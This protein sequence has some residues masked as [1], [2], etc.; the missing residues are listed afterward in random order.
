MWESNVNLFTGDPKK[1]IEETIEISDLSTS[2]LDDLIGTEAADNLR[3][4]LELAQGV[5]PD[6]SKEEYV[7]GNLQPV[8]FGSALNNFGVPYTIG[9]FMGSCL[10]P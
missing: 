6:C 3:D 2:E 9:E 5:Y 1:D 10:P 8:F 7:N 4:E